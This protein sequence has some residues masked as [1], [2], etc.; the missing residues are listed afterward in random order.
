MTE[1]LGAADTVAVVGTAPGR[2]ADWDSQVVPGSNQGAQEVV[3]S[4]ADN[5]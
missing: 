2:A 3:D 1:A 4:L 5:S